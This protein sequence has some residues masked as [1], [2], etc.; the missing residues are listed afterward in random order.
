MAV[1]A[2]LVA[3]A[4]VA[5]VVPEVVDVSVAKAALEVAVVAAD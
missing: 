2:E 1:A 3:D 4:M 5:A